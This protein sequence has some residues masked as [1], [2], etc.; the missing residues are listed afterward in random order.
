[1]GLAKPQLKWLKLAWPG[2]VLLGLVVG[3][4]IAQGPF[5]YVSI[6][7]GVVSLLS[8][9]VV[10]SSK[11]E[12]ARFWIWAGLMVTIGGLVFQKVLKTEGALNNN[13]VFH[14]MQLVGNFCFY[15]S[16]KSQV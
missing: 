11:D 12:K 3:A 10:K 6:V 8:A 16:A 5:F 15:Q 1:L 4:L 7:A 9:I 14:I 13:V 2:A